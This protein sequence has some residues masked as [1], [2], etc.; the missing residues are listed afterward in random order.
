MRHSQLL[1]ILKRIGI[2]GKDFRIIRNL[3]YEQKAAIKLREGLTEWTEVT[4]TEV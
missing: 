2:D 3:Y 4:S 1:T